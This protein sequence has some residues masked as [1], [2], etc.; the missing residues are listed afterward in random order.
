M[1]DSEKT[2]THTHKPSVLDHEEKGVVEGVLP[3]TAGS[4]QAAA[5]TL[6]KNVVDENT[7]RR[8]SQASTSDDEEHFEY[9]TKWKLAA[10][11]LALCLSVF[12]MALVG[13]PSANPNMGD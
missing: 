9:P 1:A 7:S 4:E 3:S 5:P 2:A 8:N 11:T 10:I 6:E 13:Y 12:C